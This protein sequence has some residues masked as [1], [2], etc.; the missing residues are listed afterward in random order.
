MNYFVYALRSVKDGHLYIGISRNP[1]KRLQ[2]HNAGM[3]RSTKYRR[4]FELIYVEK[5]CDRRQARE[6]EKKLKSGSGREFLSEIK[7][8]MLA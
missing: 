4:P 6:R 3:Q 2:E 5:C 1:D 7:S 8:S